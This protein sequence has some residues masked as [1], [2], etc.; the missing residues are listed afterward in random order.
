MDNKPNIFFEFDINLYE[1]EIRMKGYCNNVYVILP[2]KMKYKVCFYDP[3]RLQQDIEDEEYIAETGLIIV[4]D[5]TLFNMDSTV[6]KLWI[7]GYFESL[8]PII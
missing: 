8:K 6:N 1:D 5:V 2:N 4:K 3:V 7:T